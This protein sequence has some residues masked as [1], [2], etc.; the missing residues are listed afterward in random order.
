ML[1]KGAEFLQINGQKR[2]NN[3]ADGSG[4]INCCCCHCQDWVWD[5]IYFG[6]SLSPKWSFL[7]WTESLQPQI[8][9]SAR[10]SLTT[11]HYYVTMGFILLTMFIITTIWFWRL[12]LSSFLGTVKWPFG[13]EREVSSLSHFEAKDWYLT[14]V[15][16]G[17]ACNAKHSGLTDNRILWLDAGY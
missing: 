1:Q 3:Q 11:W 10:G 5:A 17:V 7:L 8:W 9:R 6:P 12:D 14:S 15:G 16:F 2:G 4:T 13:N